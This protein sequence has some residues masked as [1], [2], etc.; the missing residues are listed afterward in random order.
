MFVTI[1]E[2]KKAVR[3]ALLESST[4]WASPPT[5]AGRGHLY[6][7][8]NSHSREQMEKMSDQD[9]R[10][11]EMASSTSHLDDE[12]IDTEGPVPPTAENP[13][14]MQDPF[15]RQYSPNPTPA[16]HR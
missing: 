16:I 11:E 8:I 6:V 7:S 1:R 12:D 13:Y 15:V 10:R 9:I 2:I 4:E 5:P 14:V 3:L